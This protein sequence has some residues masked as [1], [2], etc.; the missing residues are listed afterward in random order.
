MTRLGIGLVWFD[1]LLDKILFY[2]F[3]LIFNIE[4]PN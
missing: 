1:F 3:G 2:Q 4:K